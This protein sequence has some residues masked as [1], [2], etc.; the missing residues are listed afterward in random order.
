MCELCQSTPCVTGC[1]NADEL[2]FYCDVCGGEI[3]KGEDYYHINGED[4]CED[5]TESC[6]RVAGE[7]D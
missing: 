4:W 5:C 6:G 2:A 1:P 3:Y 7:D